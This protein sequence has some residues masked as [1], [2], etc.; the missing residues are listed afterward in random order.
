MLAQAEDEYNGNHQ[1]CRSSWFLP[2]EVTEVVRH[3][4]KPVIAHQTRDYSSL[5]FLL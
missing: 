3:E 5:L 2:Q 4:S 1:P